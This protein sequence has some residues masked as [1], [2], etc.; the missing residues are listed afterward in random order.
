MADR[1]GEQLGNYRLIRHLGHGGFAQVYLGE[2]IYLNTLA[3]LKVLETELSEQDADSFVQ[4]AQILARL[5]HPNIVRVL[6]FAV[7][8][9]TPFLVIEY[10]AHGTLRQR[11]PKGTRLSLETIVHYVEQIAAALQYAHDQRLIHRDVK[12][13]NLLLNERSDILLSDFGLGMFTR[14]TLSQSLQQVAGT[15]FYIAPEQIQGKPRPASDQYALGIVVYEWLAGDSPFGGSLTEIVSQHLVTPP[16]SLRER[17]PGI[18]SAVEEVVLRALAK[19]PGQ[20]FASVKA[21]ATAL[22][23][24][25]QVTPVPPATPLPTSKQKAETTNT[26]MTLPVPVASTR[27]VSELVNETT[28]PP[29]TGDRESRTPTPSTLLVGRTLEWTQLMAAWQGAIAGRPQLLLLSGE[30]GIGKTRLAEAM[31]TEVGQQGN[32]TAIA[33]CYAVEGEMA[34]TPIINWLRADVFRPALETL[35]TVWL[36]EVARLLP[37]L[38]LERPGLPP[39]SPINEDWQ[40]QRLFEALA[41]VFLGTNGPLLLLLDDLQ[42]CDRETLAWIHYLLRFDP[43][44]RLLIVG[45]QRLQ[46]RLINQPLESLLV[47]LRRD[48]QMYEIPLGPLDAVETAALAE[49]VA[50]RTISPELAAHLYQE[51]EGNALFVVETIRMGVAEPQ[52]L[53]QPPGDSTPLSFQAPLSPTIQ[54]VIAT[55]L[56][57]LSPSARELVNVAAVIGRAFTYTVLKQVS[58]ADE[59][60]LV[61]ALDEMWERRIIREQGTDGYD[62]SHDKLREGAYAD[63]S[64]ARRRLLHRRVADAIE[65]LFGSSLDSHLMDLAYHFYEGGA[66]K[67][68]WEYGQRAGEQAQAM[69]APRAAIEQF[70]RALDSA[71]KGAI[72]IPTL[73][74]RLRGQAYQTLGDFEQA[75]LDYETTLQLARDAGDRQ[76]EWQALMDLGFLWSE[77]DY[78][79]AG[80]WYHQAIELARTLNDPKLEAHSLNRM[81]NWH[82]NLEQPLEALRYQRQALTIFQQLSDQHGIAQTLD[83]LGMTSYLGGDLV[84]GTAYYK[85]AIALLRQLDDRHGLTSSLATLA[86]SGATYQT[87]SMISAAPNLAEGIKDTEHALK[88]ARE[89]GQRPAEVY[90]LFQLALCL[91]SQ[92]EFGRALATAQ[93]SLDMAKEIEHREWQ[94]AAYTVLGGIYTGLLASSQAREHFEQALALAR[95]IGSQFWTCIATG[96]LASTLIA[97]EDFSYAELILKAALDPQT[98]A[99][100]MAQRLM[101]CAQV[102]LALAQ[103]DPARALDMTD[104]L[105]A[106]DPQTT[107]ERHSLRVSTLRGEALMSLQQPTEAESALTAALTIAREQGARPVQWRIYVLLG[108]LYQS[109][110]R[111][112]EAEQAFATARR[113]IEELATTITEEALRDNF[114]HQATRMFL[115]ARSLS[116]AHATKHAFGGLSKREREVAVLIAEGKSNREIAD[117]LVLS[118]RTIES[119]ISSI[120]LKLDCTSRTQI[121][122]WVIEKGLTRGMA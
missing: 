19:E 47:S 5:S 25:A 110:R 101:W 7:E 63:L 115:H 13:E 8:D 116:S 72:P 118:E 120:L 15:P 83:L 112:K 20:R 38:L 104:V 76:S 33:H 108:D 57:Q 56:E 32:A 44:A 65:Q 27:S 49:Y 51:T 114:K 107:E 78:E 103:P 66:W 99:Q 46:E 105:I 23:Q 67:Q 59:D 89:I 92:G 17:V 90:A 14:H 106:S 48:G 37:V 50:G 109:Q 24:A 31:L 87:D 68:A 77:R 29:S 69:Y 16:Q 3:A 98:P 111:H 64:R 54:D 1:V 2:H 60:V 43:F 42:W 26:S 41:R 18:T 94:T 53:E 6:D 34:Y 84:Q 36:T 88:I 10:A 121:A 28:L 75:R 30:A 122:T 95:E 86:L 9:G 74:H 80:T 62:F 73:L 117:M 61:Q 119:H 102:E 85:Q 71:Q 82:L 79:Q 21:F 96:Y 100:S 39:P 58:G 91:G 45:T 70:T 12:P 93:Q 81:G 52:G 55:R 97:L 4:E 35:D 40:R 22:Q 11:H 113:I